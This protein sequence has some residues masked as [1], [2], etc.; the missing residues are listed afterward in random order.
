MGHDHAVPFGEPALREQQRD[1]AAGG[2]GHGLA[3]IAVGDR[4][5][6]AQHQ[7]AA[8]RLG[9]RRQAIDRHRAAVARQP[10]RGGAR[11]GQCHDRAHADG[12]GQQHRRAGDRLVGAVET[13]AGGGEV[14]L[15]LELALGAQA[16]A[17]HRGDGKVRMRAGGGLL[18]QHHRVGAVDHRVGD[19]E[20]LGAGGDGRTHHRLQHLRGGD[21]RAV[22]RHR[23]ADDLLLQAGQF[24]IADFHA[25][26]AARDHHHV[27]RVDD[28]AEHGNGIGTLDLGHQRGVAAGLVQQATGLV[29]VGGGT[30]EGHRQE[31][32]A[33][34]GGQ[35][36]VGAILVRKRIDREAAALAVEP[37]AV[38]QPPAHQ[39]PAVDLLA[40]H[41]LHLE[42]DE[43][44]VEQ[45]HVAG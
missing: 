20:H 26:I 42:R 31:V 39:H 11:L 18:R 13:V 43:A 12:I 14:F 6:V 33:D 44:I 29:H 34:L 19:V 28:L 21:H 9:E 37:L 8:A 27:G 4:L 10:L 3:G 17:R 5:H 25:E 24:G 38:R 32:G 40:G 1:R 16:D 41:T 35:L 15:G 23:L 30:H 2:R 45:Q 22:A 36:D 7:H